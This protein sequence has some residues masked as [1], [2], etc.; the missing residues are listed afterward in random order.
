MTD[1]SN[2]ARDIA[3]TDNIPDTLR[4]PDT[5]A[6][7]RNKILVVVDTQVDFVMRYGLLAIAGAEAIIVPG[8]GVLTNLDAGEYAAVLFTYDTHVAADYIGSLENVGQPELGIPGFRLHCEK[9][10]NG[11]ENVFAARL[12]PAG[13]PVFEL[14]KTV[15]DAWEKPSD[16]TPVYQTDADRARIAGGAMPRDAFF[17]RL[18]AV[19]VDTA[20]VVGVASDFCVK[21]QI[22]GLIARGLKVQVIAE[23]TAGIMKDIAQTIADEFPDQV[24]I[25]AAGT[26]DAPPLPEPA[27]D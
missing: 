11:W 13:I 24:E 26:P 14:E 12:V 27:N 22:R 9:G 10:T 5:D 20:V 1:L 16:E 2:L 19:G 23:V 4:I 15:F 7:R 8:I 6:K 17:D 21:D 3:A 18:Q 25:V